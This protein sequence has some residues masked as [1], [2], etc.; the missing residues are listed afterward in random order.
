MKKKEV[1]AYYFPNWHVDPL[2]EKWH[3]KGWTEWEVT[4]CARARF[5]GHH[6]PLIPEWG[7]LDEAVEQFLHTEIVESRSEEHGSDFCRAIGFHIE[8]WI[9]A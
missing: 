6:Q 8:L 3:G 2:N 7:Y 1:Y 4:K 5:E 9:N